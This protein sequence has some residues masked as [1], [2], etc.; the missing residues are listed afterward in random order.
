MIWVTLRRCIWTCICKLQLRNFIWTRRPLT[1]Y[2]QIFKNYS[3]LGGRILYWPRFLENF[4]FQ[5]IFCRAQFIVRHPNIGQEGRINY[6]MGVLCNLW[7]GWAT[8]SYVKSWRHIMWNPLRMDACQNALP[9]ILPEI[10]RGLCGSQPPP[11]PLLYFW[12]IMQLIEAI[13]NVCLRF[14]RLTYRITH[15][16]R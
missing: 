12:F 1:G 10:L 8:T 11:A 3:R 15:P 9:N 14:C 6:R 7:H 5:F 16:L 13:K 2:D 4:H